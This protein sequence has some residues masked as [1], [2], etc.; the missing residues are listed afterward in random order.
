[1]T[2]RI[3]EMSHDR[4]GYIKNPNKPPQDRRC[5]EPV[6]LNYKRHGTTTPFAALGVKSG[7]VVANASRA[8]VP[9]SSSAS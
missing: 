4:L 7:L 8:T 6:T 5:R 9:S 3:S 1:M 2:L